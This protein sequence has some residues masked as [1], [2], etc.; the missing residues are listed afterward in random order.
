MLF[1]DLK[2]LWCSLTAASGASFFLS[3]EWHY[4]WWQVYSTPKDRL[5]IVQFHIEGQLVGILPTY[6]RK[7]SLLGPHTL[8]FLG[9]GE[10]RADEVATE[11]LDVIAHPEH[12][13]RVA[14][15]ALDW[16]ASFLA[17]NKVELRFMLDEAALVTA[18]QARDDLF[19]LE[20]K[21]GFRYRADL[22]RDEN[23]HLEG[24]GKSRLKRLNRSRRALA[25]DGGLIQQSINSAV[26]L[27]YAFQQLAALNHERQ[28]YKNRKSVF[29]SDKFNR[30]H[31]ALFEQVYD[32]GRVNI[33]Q[34]KLNHKLLAVTY[35]F[36]D[37]TTCYYYQSGFVQRM[38]NKYMPLT[39][40]HLVEMQRNRENGKL[41]YD[42]MRAE[43]PS[44]KED[45]GCE[46]T[47]M[48]TTFLF[49]SDGSLQR[50]NGLKTA[51]RTLVRLLRAV[52]IQRT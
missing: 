16:M 48:L 3:W 8:Q 40:A 46:T 50:F 43:P 37:E 22:S 4:T 38:A 2:D 45:F 10:A 14:N 36:Y 5:Y 35:C 24:L 13:Q 19:V 41:Y 39:F 28:A 44:Y 12:S 23:E 15:A 31:R 33:H 6:S 26:E 32:S 1:A 27:D 18:Y 42:L 25:R 17:W 34:F 49:C 11:Y 21:V 20:R 29:A 51:R 47:P 9:T 7:Q 52:G 30:F